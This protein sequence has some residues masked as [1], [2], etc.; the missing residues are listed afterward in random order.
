MSLLHDP[1]ADQKPRDV[2]AHEHAMAKPAQRA[3]RRLGVLGAQVRRVALFRSRGPAFGGSLD[4][5]K[6]FFELATDRLHVSERDARGHEPD[7]LPI[8]RV[9]VAPHE[10]D[11]IDRE[12]RA[13]VA[14]RAHAFERSSEL[15]HGLFVARRAIRASWTE[16]IG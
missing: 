7:E 10:T 6:N 2:V 15:L 3:L 1:C 5:P 11:G 13:D 14:V 12:T 9:L 8:E 4:A 16:S